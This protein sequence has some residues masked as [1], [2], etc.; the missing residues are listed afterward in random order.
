MKQTVVLGIHGCSGL[1]KSTVAAEVFVE[2]KKAG[3]SVE[4]VTEYVKQWAWEDRS[5]VG[6]ENS[7]YIFAKQL[8]RESILFGKVNY[9]VTD[10]PIGLSAAYELFYE[11]GRTIVHD[12]FKATRKH[13]VDSGRVKHLDFHL[14]RQFP[15]K[16]E[17]RYETE[18]EAI[19]VDQIIR[20]MIPAHPVRT[21]KDVLEVLIHCKRDNRLTERSES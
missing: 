10:C 12:L 7:L 3:E 15:F 4:L 20:S 9:I 17:G 13:Q 5:P 11:P 21:C 8:R 1:G 16:K 19:R 6:L 14:M 2:L 18:E